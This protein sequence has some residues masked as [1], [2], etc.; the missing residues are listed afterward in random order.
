MNDASRIEEMYSLPQWVR[1]A[2]QARLAALAGAEAKLDQARNDVAELL[3]H[4]RAI[5]GDEDARAWL[6]AIGAR[7]AT[8]RKV[9]NKSGI[10]KRERTS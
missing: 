3:R 5:C 7:K 9:W 10:R 4:I 2:A 1:S 6:L 8:L